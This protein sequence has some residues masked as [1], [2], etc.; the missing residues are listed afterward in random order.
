LRVCKVEDGLAANDL[1]Q[2]LVNGRYG[3]TKYMKF[4]FANSRRAISPIEKP[5]LF[6]F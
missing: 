6:P 1:K 2:K 4:T 3:E 5:L